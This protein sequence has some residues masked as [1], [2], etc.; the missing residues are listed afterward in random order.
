MSGFV[1]YRLLDVF[2]ASEVAIEKLEV[3]IDHWLIGRDKLLFEEF[4]NV[5]RSEEG[6][7]KNLGHV[8]CST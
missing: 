7:L 3:I 8:P 4:L 6:M 1:D 2:H 5:Q